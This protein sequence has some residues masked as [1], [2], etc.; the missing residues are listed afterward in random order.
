MAGNGQI[1]KRG[2]GRWKTLTQ[3]VGQSLYPGIFSESVIGVPIPAGA[4]VL[5]VD[6]VAGGCGGAPGGSHANNAPG[7]G[8]G[9]SGSYLKDFLLPVPTNAVTMDITI[10]AGGRAGLASGQTAQAGNSTSV[11]FKAADGTTVLNEVIVGCVT[12]PPVQ[13]AGAA[14]GTAVTSATGV[15]PL[16]I[17]GVSGVAGTA[18]TNI[19]STVPARTQIGSGTLF[20]V[21]GCPG[22]GVTA[23]NVGGK[24]GS[25]RMQG[26]PTRQGNANQNY[27]GDG[28]GSYGGGGCG[29]MSG[30]P[31]GA[32]G[33]AAPGGVAVA[34][35]VGGNAVAPT[36]A[37]QGFGAGGA[38]GAGGT[39]G[40]DGSAGTQGAVI[41]RYQE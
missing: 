20:Q 23:G 8:S 22:G 37:V 35:G 2:A 18:G 25:V 9:C 32:P 1:G 3:A 26:L 39:T 13:Q 34:G 36:V 41:I 30:F 27:G 24:G 33:Y 38:G 21:G 4:S 31:S 16:E 40:G 15:T 29:P 5:L 7:G 6:M 12:P 17:P 10:G 19:G 28:A 11:K 14:S